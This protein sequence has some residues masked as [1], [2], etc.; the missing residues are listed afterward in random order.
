[1][2]A[3]NGFNKAALWICVDLQNDYENYMPMLTCSVALNIS[4]VLQYF[5]AV[6]AT[7]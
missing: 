3:A 5:G 7:S 1:M 4:R 2:K 6:L